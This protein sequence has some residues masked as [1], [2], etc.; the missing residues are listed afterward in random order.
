MCQKKSATTV[1]W[2]V[3]SI[4]NMKTHWS[5]VLTYN[6]LE[7]CIFCIFQGLFQKSWKE[8]F[9][10]KINTKLIRYGKHHGKTQEPSKR[11]LKQWRAMSP[12]GGAGRPH[13]GTGR[14]P[15]V[16]VAAPPSGMFLHHLSWC[17]SALGY[18]GL[19]LRRTRIP[20]D[21]KYMGRPPWEE[22]IHYSSRPQAIKHQEP[23]S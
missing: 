17:I 22:P 8:G 12:P 21:Y 23:S 19:I 18:V 15:R 16:R 9:K 20:P 11:Y 5:M 1:D 3:R 10:C 6:F 13:H 2:S 7:F 14:R 4:V